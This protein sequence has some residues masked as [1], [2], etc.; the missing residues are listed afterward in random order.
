V[1]FSFTH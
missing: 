1:L